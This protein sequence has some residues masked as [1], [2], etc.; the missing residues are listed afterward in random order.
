MRRR[1]AVA[2]TATITAD[3]SGVTRRRTLVWGGAA[4]LAAASVAAFG[5]RAAAITLVEPDARTREL[6]QM[7]SACGA[8]ADHERLLADARAA[9]EGK[10]PMPAL[11]SVD[12][13]TCGCRLRLD[14]GATLPPRR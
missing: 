14:D 3:P 7:H 2:V 8:N 5:R 13:P 1:P 10:A 4:L 11:A 9:L 6:L 12:C